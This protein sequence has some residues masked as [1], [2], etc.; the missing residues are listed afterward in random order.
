MV[1]ILL[2]S[3]IHLSV[4]SANTKKYT[5]SENTMILTFMN[6]ISVRN[7]ERFLGI[8]GDLMKIFEVDYV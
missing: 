4:Y 2:I 1:I 5:L 7:V 8:S 6:F 3:L